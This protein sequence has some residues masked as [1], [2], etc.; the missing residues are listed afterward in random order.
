MGLGV[1]MMPGEYAGPQKTS[2]FLY[3]GC[4]FNTVFLTGAIIKEVIPPTDT[5][6]YSTYRVQWGLIKPVTLFIANPS[7]FAEYKVDDY[8]SILK[9][10]ASTKTSQL[11]ND[12]DEKKGCDKE[13]WMIL[14]LNYYGLGLEGE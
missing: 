6:A 9:D 11:W 5:V 2:P 4:Y 13:T 10:C 1:R 8:V 3:S 7:D 12:E 14:P